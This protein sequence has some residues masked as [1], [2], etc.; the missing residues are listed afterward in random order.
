M[1]GGGSKQSGLSSLLFSRFI[2]S[3][4]PS[5][6]LSSFAISLSLKMKKEQGYG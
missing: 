2:L 3:F 5:F 4:P 6:S 1:V